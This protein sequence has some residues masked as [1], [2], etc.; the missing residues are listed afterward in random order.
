MPY[1]ISIKVKDLTRRTAPDN[2]LRDKAFN[3]SK[4]DIAINLII[5]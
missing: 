2:I 3:I 5:L 4:N 1:S